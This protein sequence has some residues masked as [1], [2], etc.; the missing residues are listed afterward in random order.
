[1]NV[2][3]LRFKEFDGEWENTKIGC[4][5]EI[6]RGASP[7]P[8]QDPKW[9]DED[10]NIGWLRI[11]DVT[12]QNGRIYNLD[13][14]ISILGQQ[15]TRVLIEPHLLLSI[16]A[17][18]GKPVINYIPTGV[19]DGFLIFYR[20]IFNV[21]FM[22]QWLEMFRNKWT[23]YGQPGSQVN[24]NSDI[25]KNQEISIPSL[26]EQDKIAQ[27]FSLIDKQIQL[28][29]QKIDLLQEQKKGFLQKMFPKAGETQPEM[30]F[31]GFIGDW[32]ER[33][34]NEFTTYGSS[35]YSLSQFLKDDFQGVYPV[36]DANN[37]IARI[38]TY[39]Q[40]NDYISIIKDGAGIGRTELRPAKSSVIGTMGYI[41]PNNSDINFIYALMK[42][43]NWSKYQNGSTIPHVYYRDYGNEYFSIPRYEEQQ[44]IGLFFKKLDDTI[45]L[46]QRK[47]DIYK[48]QKKGFMQQMFI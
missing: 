9:F 4:L 24:L 11:S 38:N 25:V 39:A 6:S 41:N 42:N 23:R 5:A 18:V 47:L 13:Q 43:I 7:R 37:E 35:S 10:S 30:R 29:Q 26:K 22:F 44:Q 17:T 28:Q 36:F 3:K 21:E 48:E 19:H 34:L 27:F 15:K 20:P 12:K 14:K 32:E 45:G 40:E 46:H 33:K 1:M 16:A 8:I 2:P 31:D